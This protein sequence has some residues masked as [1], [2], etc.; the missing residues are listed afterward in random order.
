M[1][2]VA[3]TM[4]KTAIV[5]QSPTSAE[6]GLFSAGLDVV[7]TGTQI[8]GRSSG[9]ETPTSNIATDSYVLIRPHAPTEEVIS[10]AATQSL[11]I[12]RDSCRAVM[13]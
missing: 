2:G 11:C 8:S 7:A 5:G 9:T 13:P 6:R 3:A 1:D 12:A 10:G 4:T